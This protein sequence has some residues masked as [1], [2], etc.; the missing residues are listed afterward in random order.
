MKVICIDAKRRPYSYGPEVLTEGDIYTIKR[1]T[2]GFGKNG[3][4]ATAYELVEINNKAVFS[5]DR[6]IP[7]SQID[8][9]E[10]LEQRQTEL[11]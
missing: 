6:F 11:V 8:E 10:L 3:Y 1:V 4:R 7:L 5:A 2:T 9:M